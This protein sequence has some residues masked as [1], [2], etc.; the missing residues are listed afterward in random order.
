ME[1]IKLNKRTERKR[2]EKHDPEFQLSLEENIDEA[3]RM[4]MNAYK[5]GEFGGYTVDH[6]SWIH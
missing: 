2:N 1:R 3:E 4:L 6:E 5:Y